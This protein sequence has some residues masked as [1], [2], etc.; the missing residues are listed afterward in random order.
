MS[1][2]AS[3]GYHAEQM[4]VDVSASCIRRGGVDHVLRYQTFH[5]L[6]YLLEHAGRVVP[7]E[8]LIAEIWR[9][10]AVTDN[11]L[12]QC[13]AEIRKA[14]GDDSHNPIYIRTISKVGYQFVA[15]VEAVRVNHPPVH[16]EA[17]NGNG[18]TA[19]QH[20]LETASLATTSKSPLVEHFLPGSAHGRRLLLWIGLAVAVLLAGWGAARV[21]SG[22]VA[23]GTSVAPLTARRSLVVMYFNNESGN[24]NQ[25][26]LKQG[27]TDMLIT[28]MSRSGE[29]Q[30]LGREELASLRDG[31]SQKPPSDDAMRIAK[32]VRATDYLTGSF[33]SIAGQFRIDI[34]LHDSR[35]GQIIYADHSVVG[36]SSNIL[37]Q[38]DVLAARLASAMALSDATKPNLA[39]ATTK[40]LEAYQYY[41]LG[42]EKVQ[43]FENAQAVVLLKQS[44]SLDPDF[45]MAYARIGYAYALS[46]FAPDRG[47]P[48]L[49]KALQLSAHLSAKD[50]LYINSWYQISEG[51]FAAALTTLRQITQRYPE[52]A[53]AYWQIARVLRAEEHPE[54]AV[55]VLERGLRF[56]PN[57]KNLNN[58]L[59][60]VLLSLHRYPEAIAAEQRYLSLAPDEP[61]AHD[62]LGMA[63]QQSGNYPAA[64][65]HY[66]SALAINPQFE[67]SM[68]HLGDAYYQTQQYAKAVKQYQDYVTVADTS[69]ARALGYGDLAN[70]YLAM[71]RIQDAER[72]AALE[73]KNNPNAVWTSLVIAIKHNDWKTEERLEKALFRKIPTQ[74]RGS[75]GDQRTKFYYMGYIDL[76]KGHTQKALDEF[77]TAL[78]HLPPS[79]GMDNYEDCLAEAELRLGYYKDAEAEYQRILNMNPNYPFAKQRL[80]KIREHLSS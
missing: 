51:D 21:Y 14:L 42:V 44:I 43:E 70:V 7:K 25:D 8:E 13:I 47:Q 46:D 4:D 27:L 30:V 41:S 58:T 29:L 71:N 48:Y 15:P 53:E 40:N 56:A 57:D 36:D 5:V 12:T 33:A 64:F 79:S 73:I 62:S 69:T 74:E 66:Q 50:R 2:A 72:T 52:D 37:S 24:Q 68:I 32:A 55:N 34:Q 3:Y 59:G 54:Q 49:K 11:A 65:A 77:R 19:P 22:L 39:E 26:W 75:P 6:L 38:V 67:P 1:T 45:A 35:D 78:R 31:T 16:F 23:G 18:K 20:A 17:I 9:D 60:F 10:A 76:Q 61:N 80:A 63:Y 28:D